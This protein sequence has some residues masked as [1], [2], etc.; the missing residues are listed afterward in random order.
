M[1]MI[2]ETTRF[3]QTDEEGKLIAEIT[4][5]IAGDHTYII[6]HTFVDDQYRGKGLAQQLVKLVVE[7][8]RAQD[9]KII[10]L[11]PFAKAEIERTPA[12]HDV[13]R[14]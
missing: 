8:A 9:K 3:Y 12:Y 2:E 1:E 7:K 10:P 6:D 4:F 13:L 5:S 11:C 14:K